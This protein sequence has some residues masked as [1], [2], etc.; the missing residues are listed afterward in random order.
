M[1]CQAIGLLSKCSILVQSDGS[2]QAGI[3]GWRARSEEMQQRADTCGLENSSDAAVNIRERY[4][5]DVLEIL[6]VKLDWLQL[7]NY[8][9]STHTFAGHSN[10][11]MHSTRL[12][13]ASSLESAFLKNTVTEEF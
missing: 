8:R 6:N 3:R 4:T 9:Y 1:S 7:I 13:T 11:R 2:I 5:T 12:T 10:S